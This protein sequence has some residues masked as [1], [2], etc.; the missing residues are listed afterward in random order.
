MST[1]PTVAKLEAVVAPLDDMQEAARRHGV[2]IVVDGEHSAIDVAADA[3][4]VPE[5]GGHAAQ[6][7]AV[8]RAPEDVAAVAFAGNRCAVGAH[9]LVRGAQVLAHAEVQIAA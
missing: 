3:E 1:G 8:G 4:W 2:G 5:A 9:D 7:L 6:L